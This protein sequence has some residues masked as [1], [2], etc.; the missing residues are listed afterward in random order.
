M[1]KY[2]LLAVFLAFLAPG[3]SAGPESTG[4]AGGGLIQCTDKCA[5]V[6]LAK[7]HKKACVAT[8]KEC[9]KSCTS[10]EACVK[11]CSTKSCVNLCSRMKPKE[12]NKSCK[13]ERKKCVKKGKST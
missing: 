2:I 5:P 1:T 6:E 10:R 9:K 7:S 3:A 13:A 4:L 8:F 12:C 11:R